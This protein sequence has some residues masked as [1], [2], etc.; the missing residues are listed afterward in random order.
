M[1]EE[2]KMWL[3]LGIIGALLAAAVLSIVLRHRKARNLASGA[4]GAVSTE[5]L[6]QTLTLHARV[7][8]QRC[9]LT[10]EGTRLPRVQKHFW[11]SFEDDS[12]QIHQ[13]AVDEDVYNGVAVG[14]V[15]VL[16]LIDGAVLS[17]V[18]DA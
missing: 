15:G 4:H 10:R 7:V 11:V 3:V 2:Q 13:I 17:F 1:T 18:L 16:T 8:D 9:F 5:T 12:G 14:Q 6:P